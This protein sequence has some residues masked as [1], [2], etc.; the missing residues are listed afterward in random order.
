MSVSQFDQWTQSGKHFYEPMV[1]LNKIN[2]HLCSEIARE[3]V[4]AMSEFIQCNTQNLQSISSAKQFEDA[5]N[6]QVKNAADMS[7]RMGQHAQRIFDILL[8]STQEYGKWFEKSCQQCSKEAKS[9]QEKTVGQ[10]GHKH[11]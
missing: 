8:E 9:M 10:M 2:A 6:N 3:N 7:Q 4:K 1:E 11:R 5:M